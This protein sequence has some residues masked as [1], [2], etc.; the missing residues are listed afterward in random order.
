MGRVREEKRR[1]KKITK[2]KVS[3]DLRRK[4]IQVRE[5][6][7]KSRNIVFFQGFVAPEGRKKGSLKRRVRSQLAR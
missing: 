7:G 3:E 1:R 6:V 2:E 5:K 4:K